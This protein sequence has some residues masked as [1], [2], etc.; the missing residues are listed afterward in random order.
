M[1]S[2]A[3]HK[4][5]QKSPTRNQLCNHVILQDFAQKLNSKTKILHWSIHYHLSWISLQ[6]FRSNWKSKWAR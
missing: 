3:D 2:E 5:Y 4:P 6:L 1:P